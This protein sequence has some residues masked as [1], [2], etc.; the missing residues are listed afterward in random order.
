ME[1]TYT[2]ECLPEDI[3]FEGNCSAWGD[4]Q[5]RECEDY[6][7]DQLAQGNEWAWCC[8][9]V[10]ARAEIGGVVFE[11]TD[12][13]GCCS[14]EGEADFKANGP[15]DDMCGE[16]ADDMQRKLRDA[17]ANGRKAQLALRA[18]VRK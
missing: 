3:P 2:L 5:D 14:Y 16:A 11:G 4:E 13:L 9:K 12:Y 7:R 6:I 8:A 18:M 10:T 15:Y 1:I 17:I